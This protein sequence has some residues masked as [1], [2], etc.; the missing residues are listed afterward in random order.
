M[1][2]VALCCIF[3][4]FR[5]YIAV[6][7][8]RTI[9]HY[10]YHRAHRPQVRRRI[11]NLKQVNPLLRCGL[12]QTKALVRYRILLQILSDGEELQFYAIARELDLTERL[13]H[14]LILHEVVEVCVEQR[15]CMQN[16]ASN[17]VRISHEVTLNSA[18]HKL[19]VCNQVCFLNIQSLIF[20]VVVQD[21]L[22]QLREDLLELCN[23]I[24]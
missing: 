5:R 17:Q 8:L 12:E 22:E 4:Y 2:L 11:L 15:T 16:D 6:R 10:I 9:A 13:V 21:F 7:R 23:D 19:Y 14:L 1:L 20:T 3:T 24:L 18:G